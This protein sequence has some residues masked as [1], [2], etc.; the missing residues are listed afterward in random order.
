[1]A[2]TELFVY[3]MYCGRK[4]AV[5]HDGKL[6]KSSIFQ[7]MELYSCTFCE[8]FALSLYFCFTKRHLRTYLPVEQNAQKS[9]CAVLG[10]QLISTVFK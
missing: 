8:E 2:I 10:L 6:L 1:M 4:F 7:I 3:Y 9:E 5:R